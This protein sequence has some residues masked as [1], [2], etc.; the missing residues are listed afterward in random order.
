M[1]RFSRALPLG[2]QIGFTLLAVILA[3]SITSVQATPTCTST[4]ILPGGNGTV[5][6]STLGPGVC[7]QSQDKLYGTFNFGNLPQ[8][9]SVSFGFVTVAGVDQHSL[10]FTDFFQPGITYTDSYEVAVIEG[11]GFPINNFITQLRADITQTVG[12]PTTFV[13]TT[14]PAPNSGSINLSKT[15]NVISGSSIA[16]YTGTVADLLVSSTLVTG[17][18]SDTSAQLN[19]IVETQQIATTPEPVSLETLGFA[20]IGLAFG[21]RKLMFRRG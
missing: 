7:V 18:G 14:T 2:I 9:G 10:T 6:D 1:L 8:P 12:G 19:T 15:N 20:L 5:L 11:S 13:Q 16:N 21:Y 17:P 4:I 3:G